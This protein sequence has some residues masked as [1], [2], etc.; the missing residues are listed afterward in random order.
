MLSVLLSVLF[1]LRLRLKLANI[2][3]SLVF[4]SAVLLTLLFAALSR[5]VPRVAKS[6]SLVSSASSVLTP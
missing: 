5:L 1:V 4:P 2:N 3:Y 6:S